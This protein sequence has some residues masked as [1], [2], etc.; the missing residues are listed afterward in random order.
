[1]PA[2]HRDPRGRFSLPAESSFV[3]RARHRA[4]ARLAE[5]G[6]D[7]DT[8]DTAVLVVSELFTNAVVHTDSESV[9]C[10]IRLEPEAV[11]T[12][13]GHVHIT[14]RSQGLARTAA[15]TRPP[16]EEHGR[17]LLLVEAVSTAWGI[18]ESVPGRGWTVWA[19][20][21]LG[22]GRRDRAPRGGVPC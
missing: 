15:D 13:G 4:R 14:V 22:T 16:C 12:G 20:L 8:C 19:R 18:R 9:V 11:E 7:T 2:P 17:G 21:P 6:V 3:A 10:E 1:M 5:W